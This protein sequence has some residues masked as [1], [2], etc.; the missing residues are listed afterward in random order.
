M[1]NQDSGSAPA[2]NGPNAQ[3]KWLFWAC[4]VALIATSFGFIVRAQIIGDWGT[5]F[6]LSETQGG[7]SRRGRLRKQIR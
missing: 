6:S 2:V 1:S 4:L 7:D 3:E 5:R